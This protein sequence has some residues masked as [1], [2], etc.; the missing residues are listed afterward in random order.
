MKPAWI[1][2]ADSSRARIF[3]AEN[4]IANLVEIET[5]NHSEGRLNEQ[6]LES[7]ASGHAN[8]TMGVGSHSYTEETS[9]RSHEEINFAKR[10][11]QHLCKELNLNKFENLLVIAAPSFLG[12]LRSAC[13]NQL[14]KHISFSLNKNVVTL[15]PTEIRG[16]LPVSLMP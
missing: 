2:I 7:D 11:A 8:G 6:D 12:D 13:S 1:L 10:V 15:S 3:T 14:Q 9:A 16:Y 5:M 4:S